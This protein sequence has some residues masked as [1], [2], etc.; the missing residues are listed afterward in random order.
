MTRE[1]AGSDSRAG[2]AR[3]RRVG[4]GAV[5]VIDRSSAF[6]TEGVITSEADLGALVD[7]EVVAEDPTFVV[8]RA[9]PR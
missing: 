6:F 1:T 5:V 9:P 2:L 4:D 8:L 7:L 3:P